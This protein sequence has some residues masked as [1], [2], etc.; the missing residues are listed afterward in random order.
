[1][2][3]FGS[4]CYKYMLNGS[5]FSNHIARQQIRNTWIFRR[6]MVPEPTPPGQTQRNPNEL[7]H[8]MR[9]EVEE[10]ETCRPH[11]PIKVILLQEIK[12][13]GDKYEVVEV[14]NQLFNILS[15][16]R[17]IRPK[18]ESI[19][20]SYPTEEQVIDVVQNCFSDLTLKLYDGLEY[21]DRW[22]DLNVD[23]F[24][25]SIA[26]SALAPMN[27]DWGDEIPYNEMAERFSSFSLTIDN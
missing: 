14:D 8:L 18:L 22:E 5:V 17:H 9:Y 24:L 26:E 12:G 21:V 7:P 2:Y 6:V 25:V 3:S 1:M 13:L 15:I 23:E 10:Y 16:I 19:S 4:V 11:G 27:F 20:L